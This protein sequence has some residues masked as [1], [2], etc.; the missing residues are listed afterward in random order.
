MRT[1][2]KVF[3]EANKWAL[4]LILSAMS[5]IIFANV[6]LRYT[7]NFSIVWAEEVARY[8]MVWM[9]FLG[10]GL[11]LRAGSLV[12][13]TNLHDAMGERVQK[14]MRIVVVVGLLGF[15]LFMI[16]VGYSYALRMRF[17]MTPATR[18]PFSMIYAAIPIGFTLIAVHLVL[19]ARWFISDNEFRRIAG[20]GDS[21]AAGG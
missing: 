8:L 17:Q 15:F 5:V 14:F 13:I 20:V 4:I 19:V 18:I 11:A 2:E 21:T 1:A 12:A 9:T 7:T 10:A 6:A 16:W 3:I